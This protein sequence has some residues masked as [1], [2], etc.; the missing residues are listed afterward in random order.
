V[1]L[2]AEQEHQITCEHVF[3]RQSSSK[4]LLRLAIPKGFHPI[5]LYTRSCPIQRDSGDSEQVVHSPKQSKIL[6]QASSK[7][8]SYASLAK[9]PTNLS[10]QLILDLA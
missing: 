9:N 1:S 4:H 3:D 10:P 7:A 8:M 5:Q 6:A 2:A